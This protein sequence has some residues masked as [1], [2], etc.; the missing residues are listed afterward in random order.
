MI[1]IQFVQG[2]QWKAKAQSLTME[3]KDIQAV[4]G[5][6]FASGG[7]L[8]ATS[9]PYYDVGMDVN[10]EYLTDEIFN[11]NIDSLCYSLTNLFKDRSKSDFYKLL[12]NARQKGDRY[13]LLKR[14]VSYD[15]LQEMKKFPLYRLGRNK[16]GMVF[17][18]TDKRE[19]PFKLLAARTIGYERDGIQ[20]VGLEGAY[21]AELSGTSGQR[22]MQKIAGGVWMPV[23]DDNEVEPQDGCDLVSTIDINIQDVAEHALLQ[24]LIT[25]KA[26]HGCVVLMEVK[27]GKIKAIANLTRVDS[28]DYDESYNYAIGSAT[29]P[30]STFK[31]A[32]L[33]TAIQD[34]YVKPTDSVSLENGT[35]H[36]FDRVMHD[37][38]NDEHGY[39]TVQRAFEI[40]SNVG[41]SKVIYQHYSKQPQKFV[42]GLIRL[43][44][45]KP[46]D[47]S[48]PGVGIPYIP[49]TNDKDWSGTTLP[50]M[51]IGYGVTITPLQTLTLYNAVAN[52]GKM[53]NPQFVS[54]IKRQGQIVKTFKTEVINPSICSQKTIE[55]VQ[56]M[57]E[58]VVLY[59][60]AKNLRGGSYTV[61]GKTGTAQIAKGATGYKKGSEVSYQA[62]FVGYFPANKPEYSCIVMVSAPSNNVYYGALVAGPVFKEIADKVYAT[63]LEIHQA[64][65]NVEPPFALKAPEINSGYQPDINQ[66]LSDLKIHSFSENVNSDWV[67]G[68]LTDS[69]KVELYSKKADSDLKKEEVPNVIGMQAE[70]AIYLLENAGLH[71]KIIGDGTIIKQSIDAGTKITKGAQI[72]LELS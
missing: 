16:G 8:L 38:D 58:G 28:S 43:G 41:I 30:G 50:W 9:L 65:N 18:Q 59:G 45:N 37:A 31:L 70:D 55:T 54:E 57:L 36:Y 68:H 40:S 63:N 25:H 6:I 13:V 23:N 5:S 60:T 14:N 64:I 11:K 42:D 29:E 27:T 15:E 51:A 46:L 17:L 35:H 33:I 4:R 3:N 34:G 49:N 24:Q 32:S 62:T 61:A 48:I 2:A 26:D 19:R 7:S 52:N 39:V 71:V 1:E 20:P 53:V 72:V 21:N 44:L 47:L 12:V 69:S 66:V 22:L 56:K 10:T 67:F